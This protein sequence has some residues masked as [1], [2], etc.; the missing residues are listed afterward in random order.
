MVGLSGVVVDQNKLQLSAIINIKHFNFIKSEELR[1][2][3][4]ALASCASGGDGTIL[5]GKSLLTG[6]GS[7]NVSSSGLLQMHLWK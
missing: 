6:T 2:K 7:V 5:S 3:H 1:L 4:I